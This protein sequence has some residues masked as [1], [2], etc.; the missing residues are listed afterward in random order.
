MP[1]LLAGQEEVASSDVVALVFNFG[2]V[3]V[4]PRHASP[5][6]WRKLRGN[7]YLYEA[8][9][10]CFISP[11]C[12]RHALIPSASPSHTPLSVAHSLRSTPSVA[13][14]LAVC[15]TS[16]ASYS[17][18]ACKPCLCLRRPDTRR[19]QQ[20]MQASRH[21][22]RHHPGN[23][24][25]PHTPHDTSPMPSSRM[26]YCASACDQIPNVTAIMKRA[27]VHACACAGV[28]VCCPPLSH[29]GL[30]LWQV[31]TVV[32]FHDTGLAF[33]LLEVQARG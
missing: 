15:H 5:S 32:D 1:R 18:H 24:F 25:A 28:H 33:P 30:Y 26:V 20:P 3:P 10:F 14:S 17:L 22:C 9:E 6:I 13:R 27:F 11:A 8:H 23:T 19:T 2:P 31:R 7:G 12:R 4:L 16:P 29:A 21:W